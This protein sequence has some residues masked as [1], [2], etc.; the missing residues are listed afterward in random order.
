[1]LY[2][3]TANIIQSKWNVGLGCQNPTH[4]MDALLMTLTQL[5]Q[6]RPYN[7]TSRVFGCGSDC[8]CCLVETFIFACA[9]GFADYLIMQPSMG[10]YH[11]V[12]PIFN[13]F[14]DAIKAINVTSERSYAR[15]EDYATKKFV[16]LANIRATVGRAKWQSDPTVRRGMFCHHTLV[17]FMT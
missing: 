17:C 15:G 2:F 8:F 11:T 4:P 5:K 13:N 7:Y 6:G 9:D 16:G 1:M 14:P 3:Q 12:G 10:H